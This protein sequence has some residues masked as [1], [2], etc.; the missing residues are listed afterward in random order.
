M[1]YKKLGEIGAFYSLEQEFG[2]LYT[3][4]IIITD[5][6]ESHIKERHAEDYGLFERYGQEVVNNPDIVVKDGKNEATAFMIKRLPEANL[7]V[8]VKV[9]VDIKHPEYKNSVITFYRLR[10]RNLEKMI[11]KKINRIIY[12]K[13]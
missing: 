5:E 7:N 11:K 2:K 9:A 10:N 8:T 1:E 13:K 12:K 4:E 3:K 6:R